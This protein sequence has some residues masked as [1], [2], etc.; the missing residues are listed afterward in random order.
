MIMAPAQG[1]WKG[2]GPFFIQVL[3]FVAIKAGLYLILVA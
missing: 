2:V 1:G 3:L